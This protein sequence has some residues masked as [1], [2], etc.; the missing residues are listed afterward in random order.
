M[1]ISHKHKFIFIHIYKTAGTSISRALMPYCSNP[2]Q[3]FAHRVLKRFQI[4]TLNPIP[5][6]KHIRAQKLRQEMGQNQF[7]SY[8]SFSVVRN[9]WDWNV[10]L[11]KY[12]LDDQNH[13][14]HERVK[15]FKNFDEYIRERCKGSH[16]PQKDFT[17]SKNGE[18]LVDFIARFEN[19]DEDFNEIC[20]IIGVKASL[21]HVNRS[22]RAHYREFYSDDTR[23]LVRESFKSDIELFEYEF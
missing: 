1:L 14:Q 18:K 10:S 9:P 20:S 15:N 23:E 19:L 12:M 6:P 4:R 22:K 2:L 11:Y 16:S 7:N 8:F 3:I 17:H 5:Y 13:F 21:P